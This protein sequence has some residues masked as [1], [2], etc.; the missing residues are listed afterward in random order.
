M[1]EDIY[2]SSRCRHLYLPQLLAPE[3]YER[4]APFPDIKSRGMGRSGRDLFMGEPGYDEVVHR[5]GY[6]DLYNLFTSS[7]FVSWVLSK[8]ADDMRRYEC[9][10]DAEDAKLI[11]PPFLE[12]REALDRAPNV[13][14]EDAPPNEL[15]NRFDFTIAGGDYTPYVHLDSPRRVVGGLLFFSDAEEEEMEGGEFTLYRDLLFANDRVA[16]LPIPIKKF[17]VRKNSGV[18]FLNCNAGFHGPN[19]IRSL[20]GTR[21]WVYCSISSRNLAWSWNRPNVVFRAGFKLLRESGRRWSRAASL[22]QTRAI[23]RSR[24]RHTDRGWTISVLVVPAPCLHAER[25]RL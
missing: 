5:E 2:N 17:P 10:F 6:S 3:V 24:S 12:T 21:R 8:F 19:P 20:K 4:L 22:K 14:D 7:E 23:R 25:R 13:L 15:F 16:H 18:L 9:T 1:L 11:D